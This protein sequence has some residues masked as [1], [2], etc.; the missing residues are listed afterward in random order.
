M[1]SKQVLFAFVLGSMAILLPAALTACTNSS[2]EPQANSPEQSPAPADESQMAGMDH[3]SEVTMDD[4]SHSTD[5][6]PKDG[7]FDLRFI[8]AMIPHHQTTVR[9]VQEALQKSTRPE[10][11]Q[12]SQ[13]LAAA[14]ER[15]IAQMQAWRTNWYPS[16]GDEPMMYD[17]Q[18]GQTV[19]M[20]EAM[21]AK[22]ELGN[23]DEQFDLRLIEALIPHLE[24]GIKMAQQAAQNSDRPEMKQLAQEAIDSQQQEI[25]RL[26]QWKQQWY[27][28]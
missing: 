5:L 17:A 22:E 25:D 15:E 10:I 1:K 19:P 18:T 7:S 24:G 9:L 2:P 3:G 6:G 23:A 13:T 4:M 8:D 21:T 20:P 12:F 28:Q 26:K 11:Q 16:A 27:G 14:Q